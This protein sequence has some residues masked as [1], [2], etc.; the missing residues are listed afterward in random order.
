MVVCLITFRH[1]WKFGLRH[2]IPALLNLGLKEK[3]IE[4]P[5]FLEGKNYAYDMN[6]YIPALL[7]CR[8]D[9][10][11]PIYEDS[12]SEK[13]EGILEEN[14]QEIKLSYVDS[15]EEDLSDQ[16]KNVPPG[17]YV[18]NSSDHIFLAF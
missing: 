4:K 18:K 3:T 8:N 11:N 1:N 16:V 2:I 14:F 13:D 15:D 17:T 5:K 12:D 9:D 10:R 6:A 7:R